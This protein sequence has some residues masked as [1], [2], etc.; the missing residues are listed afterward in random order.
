MITFEKISKIY[1]HQNTF[2]LKDVSFSI[3]KGEFFGL[4]G[5]NGA[6]KTTLIKILS[7]LYLPSSGS[8][9]IDHEKLMRNRSDLKKKIAVM[10]QEFSLRGDMNL[11]EA[12]EL[13]GKLYGLEKKKIIDK[14]E[15]LFQFCN[16]IEHR[17]K[18]CRKLSGGMKRKLMLCRSLLTEP[19]ILILDEPTVGLDPF[20]RRQIWDILRQLN[21]KGMTILLTTHYIDEAEILCKR[22]ALINK[23]QLVEM[24]SPKQFI[25]DLGLIAVDEFNGN[26]TTTYF[27]STNDEALKFAGSLKNSFQVRN[28]TLEDVFIQIVGNGVSG[29]EGN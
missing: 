17:K 6:G 19:E 12:M 20:S 26:K 3:E 21:E 23:G 29:N 5:P 27:F 22:I 13:Q 28:T 10:S 15:Q 1:P 9:E 8:I 7:T 24:K 4:L 11:D 14:T 25:K 16:L 18:T 2:A